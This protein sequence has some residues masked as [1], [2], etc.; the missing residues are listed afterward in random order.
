MV[1]IR[2]LMEG[3]VLGLFVFWGW[4]RVLNVGVILY[5]S[6]VGLSFRFVGLRG[7]YLW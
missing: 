6:S 2:Y 5:F 3:V 1:C 7:Y 4:S